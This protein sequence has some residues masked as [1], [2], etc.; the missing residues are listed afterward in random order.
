[1]VTELIKLGNLRDLLIVERESLSTSALI[2]MAKDTA[3]G[4][5]Y[6]ANNKIIH[7]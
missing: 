2:Q 5:T 1:M 3:A 7:R 6:L 4:L